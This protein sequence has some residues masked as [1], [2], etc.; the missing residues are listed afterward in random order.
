MVNVNCREYVV[1]KKTQALIQSL[2]VLDPKARL[3][4]SQVLDSLRDIIR[5]EES[6]LVD[7][8]LQVKNGFC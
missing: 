2:L 6:L 3:T 5:L 7:S 1:S 4:A 8:D